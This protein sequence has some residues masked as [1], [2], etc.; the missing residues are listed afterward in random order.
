MILLN[1]K[2]YSQT[3][4]N[5]A[6]T[7]A[8]IA[9]R[10]MA[11]TGVQI[12]PVVSALDALNI[13]EKVG[14][15]VYLQHVDPYFEGSHT[16]FISPLHAKSLGIKGSLLNHSEHRL[17]PGTLKQMFKSWPSDFDSVLCLQSFGQLERWDNK[18]PATFF[19]YEPK[20]FI[21]NPQ[22]SVASEC[23]QQIKNF[24]QFLHTRPLL[25]GAGIRRPEDIATGLK[26]GAKGVL[27]ASGVIKSTEPEKELMALATAFSV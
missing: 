4:S 15:D 10:V 14:I 22:L 18:L 6:L 3:F 17:S 7:I 11:K 12:I 27:I 20:K 24:S 19:A 16:G 26:L 23:P 9:K 8:L 13:K 1:N 21:G 2:I 5:Q 25:I